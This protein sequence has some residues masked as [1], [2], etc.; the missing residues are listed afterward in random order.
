M[1]SAI[2]LSRIN[3]AAI[4][5]NYG[6]TDYDALLQWIGDRRLVLIGEASHGT[7]DFY[8][9][10]ARI[11]RRLIEEKGFNMVAIEGDWPDAYRVNRFVRGLGAGATTRDANAREALGDFLRFPAWM[12]RNMDVLGFVEWMWEFNSKRSA[13]AR[14][15]FYGLDLYS[16]HASIRAVLGY[17]D[18]VDPEG[19]QRARYRYACFDHF[20]EDP[21]AYGYASSFKLSRSCEDEVVAQLVEMRRRCGDLA[22]RD[23]RVDPDAYFFAEQN[24]RLI[25]NAESYYRAMFE[26]RAESWNVRDRHMAESLA[27]LCQIRP[28]ARIVVWAHNSHL[29]D[30]S[31]TEMSARGEVNLGQLT[32]ERFGDEVFLLGFTTHSGEVTAA[33]RWDAPAERKI[34][35]PALEG[36]Y[37]A[38]FH[39]TRI[40]SFLLP[41]HDPAVARALAEPRLERAIGVIYQPRTERESHYFKCHLPNQFDAVIHIDRTKALIP[42]ELTSGWKAGELPETYPY[43]V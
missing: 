26:G 14:A 16:L 22:S 13:E 7:H 1:A 38:M 12:W 35:R 43:A 4:P 11:T 15:G 40:P 28:K 5:L 9:E 36:S 21:Q 17:L 30:A 41:M 39:Q 8:R 29:G 27:W 3:R 24:A 6:A 23:G 33:A 32:R 42:F 18:K 20:G 25:R 31:A 34:V 19:A 2:T 10:R 37:E